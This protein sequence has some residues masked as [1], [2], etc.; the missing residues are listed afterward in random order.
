MNDLR[1]KDF[2]QWFHQLEGF[3]LL[4]E[5]FYTDC[6]TMNAQYITEWLRAAFEAAREK[7]E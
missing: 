2:N 4:S 1:Y 3:H 5:R 6:E 7:Y